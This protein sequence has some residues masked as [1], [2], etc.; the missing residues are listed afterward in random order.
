[1]SFRFGK[2]SAKQLDS[3]HP[4][5]IAVANAALTGGWQDFAVIEGHRSIE[6]QHQLFLDGKSTLDGIESRG[7]HN[8]YPSEAMDLLPCP[9][10]I[11][12]VNIWQDRDRFVLFAGFIIGI[13]G[14]LGIKLTWGGDWN[15]D[16]SML[17]TN[18]CD[19]P[20]FELR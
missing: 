15:N 11:H 6:R 8:M 10:H 5:L 7:R 13:A 4:Y 9:A 2:S 3:C 1:M 20:H 14:S 12:G 18:F 17:D 19:L 16:R